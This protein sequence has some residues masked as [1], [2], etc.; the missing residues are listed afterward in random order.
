MIQLNIVRFCL[1]LV[2]GLSIFVASADS[3]SSNP[4]RKRLAFKPLYDLLALP[5]TQI[6]LAR[7][8]LT[9]ERFIDPS[10]NIDENLAEIENIV[11][12]IKTLPQYNDTNDGKLAAM[13]QYLYHSGSWNNHK[14]YHYDFDDPLGTLKPKNAL[15]S[16]YLKTHVGNCVSMPILVLILGQ[17][18]GLDMRLSNAP[19][20]LFVRLHE[21]G[22]TYNFESTVGGF[23]FNQSYI[24]EYLITPEALRNKIYLQS[25]TKKE[26]VAVMLTNL[27]NHY[28]DESAGR[29]EVSKALGL[30]KQILSHY[31]NHIN[32]ILA[33]AN[34]WA[35]MLRHDVRL[36]ERQGK[37]IHQVKAHLDKLL[38]LNLQWFAK[39]ESLGWQEPPAD[40][41]Q[42][43]LKMVEQA[44][45]HHE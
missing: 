38:A 10:I 5:E 9:I 42:Q 44:R 36:F 34:A 11:S 21:N 17:K 26:T 13:V 40:Y 1:L 14:K 37:S 22:A 35:L 24:K 33:R 31:P 6:D 32:A 2:M 8:Q 16:N 7:A 25:L 19:L 20:H 15:L 28:I 45:Q 30:T 18:L 41:D 12:L 23:K 29:E 4:D 43:Y 39:A 27:V 3:L